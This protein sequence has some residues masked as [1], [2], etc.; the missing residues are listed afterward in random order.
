MEGLSLVR[1]LGAL[2]D[3][4]SSLEGG[5]PWHFD[6]TEST[7]SLGTDGAA[8]SGAE[9]LG[10]VNGFGGRKGSK[11]RVSGD[12]VES[13]KREILIRMGPAPKNFFFRVYFVVFGVSGA[14]SGSGGGWGDARKV[15]AWCVS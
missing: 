4:Q 13:A 6:N 5:D 1:Q 8:R 7:V 12:H 2:G 15:S 3:G 10:L 9:I 14:F 11:N